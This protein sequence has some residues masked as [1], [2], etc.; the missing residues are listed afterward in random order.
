MFRLSGGQIT[1]TPPPKS[2]V[3]ANIGITV[4]LRIRLAM[5]E[6][7]LPS[8]MLRIAQGHVGYRLDH[9]GHDGYHSAQ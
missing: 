6:L 2:R 1:A 4:V 3:K 5:I 7:P 8:S 9:S